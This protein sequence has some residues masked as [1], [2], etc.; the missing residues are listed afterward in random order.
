MLALALRAGFCVS[1][2]KSAVQ[3]SYLLSDL[4]LLLTRPTFSSEQG[5]QAS[6][7]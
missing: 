5:V 6:G 3:V 2:L 1:L 4:C 7:Y